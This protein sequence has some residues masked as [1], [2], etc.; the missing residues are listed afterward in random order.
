MATDWRYRL[1]LIVHINANT[2]DNRTA[3]AQA[4][5]DNGGGETLE[6]ERL[7]FGNA[8]RLALA[9]TPTIHRAYG[10]S[11]PVKASMRDALLT[12]LA[13]VDA[14]LP[15]AQKSVYYGLANVDGAVFQSTSYDTGECFYA[16]RAEDADFIGSGL[17]TAMILQRLNLVVMA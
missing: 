7:M 3:F 5:V 9:S 17:T 10:L 2:A 15:A 13:Q 1:I 12:V 11:V 8:V 4:F 16:N 14:P 6:N